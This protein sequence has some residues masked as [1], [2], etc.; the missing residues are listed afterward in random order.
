[1]AGLNAIVFICAAGRKDTSGNQT[2]DNPLCG[3]S[4][5]LYLCNIHR[6]KRPYS[7]WSEPQDTV[8]WT[9]VEVVTVSQFFTVAPSVLINRPRQDL[10]F[11][12]KPVQIFSATPLAQTIGS[13]LIRY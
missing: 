13:K 2:S 6:E 3:F 8:P 11:W 5:Q 1:M 12:D 4:P 10:P 9:L 7:G